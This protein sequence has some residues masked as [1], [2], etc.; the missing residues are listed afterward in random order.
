MLMLVLRVLRV[1]L[2]PVP[3]RAPS[4]VLYGIDATN[5]EDCAKELDPP[6]DH[7]VFNFP[8][9]GA[10]KILNVFILFLF[11]TCNCLMDYFSFS[12]FGEY[13]PLRPFVRCRVRTENREPRTAAHAVCS[14]MHL[15]LVHIRIELLFDFRRALTSTRPPARPRTPLSSLL[16]AIRLAATGVCR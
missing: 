1:L 3:Y 10:G 16:S 6:Y 5:L 14:C 12:S 13:N 4:Q 11:F 8:H 2:L 7:V 15:S 9:A